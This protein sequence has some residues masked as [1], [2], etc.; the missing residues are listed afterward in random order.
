M[1]PRPP[2]GS[3]AGIREGL[4]TDPDVGG[5]IGTS[6]PYFFWDC[7]VSLFMTNH[8]DGAILQRDGSTYA[9]MVRSPAGI[10]TPGLLDFVRY[11]PLVKDAVRKDA[12]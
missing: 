11:I 5:R 9:V 8:P 3:R 12:Q 6:I 2:K 1:R 10:V 7:G 4:L